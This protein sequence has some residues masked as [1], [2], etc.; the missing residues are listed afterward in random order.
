MVILAPILLFGLCNPAIASC[1]GGSVAQTSN[2]EVFRHRLDKYPDVIE[3]LG[4]PYAAPPVGVLRFEPPH[5][6]ILPVSMR[7]YLVSGFNATL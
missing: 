3:Y 2:S 6:Y 4:I 7:A 5:A 1:V